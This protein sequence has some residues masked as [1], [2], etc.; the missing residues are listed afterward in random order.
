[1]AELLLFEPAS[2]AP[3]EEKAMDDL[4]QALDGMQMSH[5]YLMVILNRCLDYHKLVNNLPLVPRYA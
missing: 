4:K 1:M 3:K 2:P 5:M